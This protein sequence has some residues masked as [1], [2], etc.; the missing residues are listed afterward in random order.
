M[1]VCCIRCLLGSLYNWRDNRHIFIEVFSTTAHQ[2]GNSADLFNPR[3]T[4]ASSAAVPMGSSA[5]RLGVL[6][7][8]S[9]PLLLLFSWLGVHL[10]YS[11]P[12]GLIRPLQRLDSFVHIRSIRRPSSLSCACLR[13]AAAAP[14]RPHHCC[15]SSSMRVL[16]SSECGFVTHCVLLRP[17]L[18]KP[19]I[20]ASVHTVPHL[21]SE[22]T[23][24]SAVALSQSLP[25]QASPQPVLVGLAQALLQ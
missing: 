22:C 4:S 1:S 16:H 14:M 11:L 21:V 8:Y 25:V 19:H 17:E 18:R 12:A 9:L 15:T 2:G 7:R 10:R 5:L 23:C 6:H 13:A 3:L 24:A 20:L